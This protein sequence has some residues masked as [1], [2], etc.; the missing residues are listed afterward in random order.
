[1]T[2]LKVYLREK[3]AAS[4]NYHIVLS[5]TKNLVTDLISVQ[6]YHGL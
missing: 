4:F 1:M 3:I 6:F 5:K 2:C